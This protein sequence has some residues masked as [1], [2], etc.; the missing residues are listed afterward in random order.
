ME[1]QNLKIDLA[2][3]DIDDFCNDVRNLATRLRYPE[4]AQ[5]MAI[6]AALPPVVVTQVINITTFQEI[7]DTL[8][9]LVKNPVIKMVLLTE[10]TGEKGMAPFH[11]GK[12][13]W[14]PKN[15]VGM[16]DFG[17]HS[18][19]MSSEGGSQRNSKSIGKI[20]NKM[21]V[22]EFKMCKMV[23]SEERSQELLYKPQVAS[24]RHRGGGSQNR[25]T[26]RNSKQPQ[27]YS[28]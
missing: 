21:D 4:D 19:S 25:G 1:W 14:R 27:S 20:M 23:T 13:Q 22:L 28:S 9:T 8:I 6:K 5:L 12:A 18:M 26:T 3:D 16:N 11:I 17:V 7:R 15:D 2:K 24:P 10:G